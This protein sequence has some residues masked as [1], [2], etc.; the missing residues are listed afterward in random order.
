VSAATQRL[1][2][3]RV[4]VTRPKE[5]ARELCFLLEDEGA[6]VICLPMLELLPP[7]DE[8]PLLAAAENV[9]RYA[10]I[11]FASPSA[12]DA[13]FEACRHAGTSDR[14]SRCKLAVVGPATE[15]AVKTLGLTVTVEATQSSGASLAEAMGAY[16]QAEDEVLLPAAEQGRR[17]LEEGLLSL[18]ARVTRVAAYASAPIDVDAGM[19]SQLVDKPPVLAFVGSPRT[20]EALVELSRKTPGIL[21]GTRLVAIGPTTAE[22]LAALGRPVA[23]VA[24]V[25][26]AEAMVEAAVSV[27]PTKW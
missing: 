2:G 13:L 6:D 24:K 19:V 10:W 8:R 3:V 7:R 17:E 27:V 22:A 25:A 15:R 14:L 12:V 21:E 23:A 20:A 4:L 11:A 16:V 1:A 5:R 18:G 26:T 9:Q